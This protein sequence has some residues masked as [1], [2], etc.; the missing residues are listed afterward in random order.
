[1]GNF[2]SKPYE[3]LRDESPELT[4]GE[5]AR[6]YFW[7]KPQQE[8][9]ENSPKGTRVKSSEATPGDSRWNSWLNL[10]T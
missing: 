1:M 7:R 6:G 8:L 5:I 10:Q 4:S 3:K 2:W 9:P